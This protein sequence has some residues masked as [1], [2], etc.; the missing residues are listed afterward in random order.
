MTNEVG[1]LRNLKVKV[2]GME[3]EADELGLALDVEVRQLDLW[4]P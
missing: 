2:A 1:N 3:Q 4:H